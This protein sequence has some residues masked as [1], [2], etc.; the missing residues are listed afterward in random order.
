VW[1]NDK[2]LFHPI[3][4]S[5]YRLTEENG[6]MEAPSIYCGDEIRHGQL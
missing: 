6:R 2:E 4:N 5:F 3:E 1:G